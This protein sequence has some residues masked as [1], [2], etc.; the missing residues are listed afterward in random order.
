MRRSRVAGCLGQWGYRGLPSCSMTSRVLGGR[1]SWVST[2]QVG[3][4][5]QDREQ[6]DKQT[7]GQMPPFQTISVCWLEGMVPRAHLGVDTWQPCVP[8]MGNRDGYHAS[9]SKAAG[10]PS[11]ADQPGWHPHPVS[12]RLPPTNTPP[13][14]DSDTNA[15]PTS[16]STWSVYPLN[17]LPGEIKTTGWGGKKGTRR[18][19][20]ITDTV[21]S[22]QIQWSYKCAG[23]TGHHPRLYRHAATSPQ[24]AGTST[25]PRHC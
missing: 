16:V 9:D 1:G 20:F 17:T 11:G 21:L 14:R 7:D 8:T 6:M 18:H 22:T 15:H 12:L 13:G 24:G 25:V 4:G 2:T 23:Q 10:H 3:E 5:N 19:E